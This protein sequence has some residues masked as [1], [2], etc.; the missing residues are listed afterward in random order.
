MDQFSRLVGDIYDASLDPDRWRPA[1]LG[2]CKFVN[3]GFGILVT[4]DAVSS[5]A[6][7]HYT[8]RTIRLA[9]QLFSQVSA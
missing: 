5:K 8:S 2:V 6:H 7:V 9:G 4:E 3:A 1:P